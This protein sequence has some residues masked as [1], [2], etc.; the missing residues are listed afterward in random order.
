MS[1][2]MSWFDSVDALPE[3]G[4]E[5]YKRLL[6]LHRADHVSLMLHIYAAL[7]E[8]ERHLIALRTPAAP[9][10]KTPQ[11]ARP[12]NNPT[13]PGEAQAEGTAANRS[14]TDASVTNGLP[15][16]RQIQAA[17]ATT[18]RAIAAARNARGVRMAQ[19]G[20]WRDSTMRNLAAREGEQSVSPN[21][22]PA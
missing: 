4:S 18:H 17:G 9:A 11:G 6:P 8:K 13:N 1:F 14:A 15:F 20:A 3:E 21:R 16:V 7:A 5:G 12:A 19:G 22:A 2:N 10:R